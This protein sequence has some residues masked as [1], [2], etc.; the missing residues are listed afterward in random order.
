MRFSCVSTICILLYCFAE[1]NANLI[2]SCR[3]MKLLLNYGFQLIVRISVGFYLL[4]AMRY[5]H[6]LVQH[7]PIIGIFYSIFLRIIRHFLKAVSI[8]RTCFSYIGI[9]NIEFIQQICRTCSMALYVKDKSKIIRQAYNLCQ[10]CSM[11]GY[12]YY[13]DQSP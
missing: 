8:E 11:E 4:C 5:P 10:S 13:S 6:R 12:Y 9:L 2:S 3:K 7:E 1:F